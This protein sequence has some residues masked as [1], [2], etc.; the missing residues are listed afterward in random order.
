LK[1]FVANTTITY[2]KYD[3]KNRIKIYNKENKGQGVVIKLTGISSLCIVL[4]V[5]KSIPIIS[6]YISFTIAVY[7]IFNNIKRKDRK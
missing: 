5:K 6:V 7:N 2:K 4:T 3:D 1:V